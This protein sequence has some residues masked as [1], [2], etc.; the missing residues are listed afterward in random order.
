MKHNISIYG[1]FTLDEIIIDNM[2]E[3]RRI[4]GGAYYSTKPFINDPMFNFKIHT[5]CN[6]YI[7]M[8]EEEYLEH[9]VCEAYS[10]HI[11][12]FTLIY[13]GEDREIIVHEK[14]PS[15]PV[16]ALIDNRSYIIANPVLNEINISL[17]KK[18]RHNSKLLAID[19]QGFIRRIYNNTVVLVRD[20]IVKQVLGTGNIVHLS[21]YEAKKL[22]GINYI[23]LNILTKYFSKINSETIYIITRDE[24][25]PIVIHG[26]KYS[27][28]GDTKPRT[29]D[30]TGAGDYFLA[31]FVK[32]YI[33]TNDITQATI[34]AHDN[35]SNWLINRNASSRPTTP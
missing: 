14:L 30:R 34:K 5:I 17:L 10:T 27:I 33:L 11:N 8:I 6:P 25:P 3:T 16:N 1:N 9:I 31:S 28:L 35:T 22:V 2:V 15:L 13:R 18:I 19:I 20:S 23:D 7:N 4:G 29:I 12:L 24:K 21:M 26:G 32:E